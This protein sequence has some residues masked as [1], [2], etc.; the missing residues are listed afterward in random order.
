MWM[1]FEDGSFYSAVVDREDPEMFWVRSRDRESSEI[2]AECVEGEVVELE[3]RDYAF[4]VHVSRAEWI[5]F[6]TSHALGAKAT[7]FKS[8]VSKNRGWDSKIVRALHDIWSVMFNYQKD[9]EKAPF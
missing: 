7:N 4:R 3:S 2:L 1:F 9:M 6:L 8:E 5:E